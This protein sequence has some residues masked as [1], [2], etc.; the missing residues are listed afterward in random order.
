M[1]IV[2]RT[3]IALLALAV[4]TVGVG[5]F[6]LYARIESPPEPSYPVT[7][8]LFDSRY[9]QA[10]HIALEQLAQAR[11]RRNFPSISMAVGANGTLVWAGAVGYEQVAAGVPATPAT[12]YH[13]ASIAKP[14]TSFA[15]GQLVQ[16]GIIDLDTPF[17][18]LVPDFGDDRHSYTVR[19]L[20][21]HRAGIRHHASLSEALNRTNFESLR[22]AA[23]R[24]EGDP[25]LFEPGTGASYS[26]PGYT[27][28]GLAME[29]AANK[30]YLSLMEE[31]VFAPL[32]MTATFADS[33]TRPATAVAAPYVVHD[34][35]IIRG[36]AV[37]FSDRWAGGGFFSTPADL[38][39]FGNAVLTGTDMQAEWWALAVNGSGGDDSGSESSEAYPLLFGEGEYD[40]GRRLSVGGT[41]WGGRAALNVYPRIGVVV[42]I[43]TNSRPSDNLGPGIDLDAIADLFAP[44][45]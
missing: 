35:L 31:L 41:G 36:P 6:L 5:F 2:G 4:A 37:N 21:S 20:Q 25:L 34:D 43:A 23:S 27:L 8:V 7:S 44:H 3:L 14:F 32:E 29:R 17:R 16:G 12:R 22:A 45:D 33:A 18:M 24:I 15:L 9:E 26:T 19:H 10:G 30:P 11:R 39:T 42:A 38:V 1:R 40:H 28:L 13:V